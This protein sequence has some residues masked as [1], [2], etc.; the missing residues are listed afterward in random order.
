MDNEYNIDNYNDDLNEEE[1]KMFEETKALIGLISDDIDEYEKTNSILN[2]RRLI[3][4]RLAYTILK[5]LFRDKDVK[6]SYKI[7]EPFKTMG[8]ITL[9][10]K[11]LDFDSAEQFEKVIKLSSNMQVNSLTS[12][13]VRMS[14]A[15]YGIT[16]LIK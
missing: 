5:Q 12:D 10:G 14:F 6:I 11:A 8:Y 9:E 13:N 7:A 1:I 4:M 2:P 15:F 16:K 3:Q